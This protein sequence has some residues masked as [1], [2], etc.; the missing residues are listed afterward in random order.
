MAKLVL[1]ELDQVKSANAAFEK[2]LEKDPIAK[3]ERY[4]IERFVKAEKKRRD[5]EH[6]ATEKGGSQ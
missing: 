5:E 6:A 4:K 1:I 2:L 3:R